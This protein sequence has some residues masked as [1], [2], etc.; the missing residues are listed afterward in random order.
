M[1]GVRG[2]ITVDENTEKAIGDAARKLISVMLSENN[3]SIEDIASI[4]FTVTHDLN[5]AFPAAAVRKLAGFSLVPMI[6]ALEID[7][8]GS[9][10]HCIRL[11]ML[12][13]TGA[14]QSDIKHVYLNGAARLRPDLT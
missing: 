7:V 14:G 9:L 2:A 6:C 11:L 10:K 12:V 3:F 8:P 4:T 13:N 5:A 1:R